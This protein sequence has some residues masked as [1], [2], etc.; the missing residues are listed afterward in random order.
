MGPEKAGRWLGLW[1][2]SVYLGRAR[3]PLLWVT[4]TNDFAYPMGSLQKSYRLPQGPRTLCVRIRMP[5]GHGGAGE[6]PEEIRVFAESLLNGG[7]PLPKITGQSRD[8]SS[9]WVTYAA[10]AP[11]SRAEL[12]YTRALGKWQ[13]R[14]WESVPAS[15]HADR[16]AVEATLPEGVT[17]YYVNLFD[18]RDC[19]VSTEHEELSGAAGAR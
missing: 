3:M 5:H 18:D 11:V 19:A 12:T 10:E 14:L 2:P 16:G 7:K 15:V 8:D 17:A 13:D 4:G 1:D 9:I 6:N